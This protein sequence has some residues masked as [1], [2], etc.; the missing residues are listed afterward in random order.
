MS[1]L[2][3]RLTHPALAAFAALPLRE[4]LQ[5]R[6][7]LPGVRLVEGPAEAL[8][9]AEAGRFDSVLVADVLYLL[10]LE[11]QRA[12][13]GTCR[14]LLRPGGRLVLKEAEDDG[15][16]RTAKALWQERL[17][18]RALGRTAA[19]GALHFLPRGTTQALLEEAGFRV[20]EVSSWKRHSTTP[21]IR[22]LASSL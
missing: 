17:M 7:R 14:R 13:L 20:L 10:P 21:H 9:P 19:S 16:W 22:F 8:L 3:G 18:V 2:R 15:G 11:A 4:R 12:L 1:A 6:G 5:V